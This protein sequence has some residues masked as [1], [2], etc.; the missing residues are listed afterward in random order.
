MIALEQVEV[1]NLERG[2][3]I[4]AGLYAGFPLEWNFDH[5]WTW[6]AVLNGE[7]VAYLLAGAIQGVV[8]L[9]VV[10]SKDKHSIV[11][12]RLFRTFLKDCLARGYAGWM[13]HLNHDKPEQGKLLR[14][15]KRTGAIIF[16]YRIVCVGGRIADAARW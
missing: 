15:A 11:L 3:A 16:P 14:I 12:P 10:K 1:R 5:D 9:M 8:M 4:P 2:E 13:T 7:I 6:V